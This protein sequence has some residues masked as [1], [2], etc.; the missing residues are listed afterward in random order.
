M[1]RR[2]L[3]VCTGVVLLACHQGPPPVDYGDIPVQTTVDTVRGLLSQ[4]GSEP[5]VELVITPAKGAPLVIMG[6]QTA[7]LRSLGKVEVMLAGRYPGLRSMTAAPGGLRAFEADRFTVRAADGVA[8]YD[9]VIVKAGSSY[10]LE[11]PSGRRFAVDHLPE[12]LRGLI[13]ARVFL[14][15]PLDRDPVSYGVISE[16]GR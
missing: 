11:A 10:F 8:A 6:G 1:N 16:P 14:A 12:M 5:A 15:G 2:L 13:G 4:V 9:G 7:R 3:F